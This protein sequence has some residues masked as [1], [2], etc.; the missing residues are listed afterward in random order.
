MEPL[1]EEAVRVLGCLVEKEATVPD[2]YPLTLNALRSAC[3]Q[4]SSRDPVV[5]YDDLTVQRSLDALKAAGLVRFVHPSH[6]ERATKFRHT[7]DEQLGLDHAALSVLSLLALRGPQTTGELRTRAERQHRF[8]SSAD[9][10]A[11]LAQLAGR[12]Q[13]L[14]VELPRRPGH[15]GTRWTHLLCGPVDAEAL[16]MAPTAGHTIAGAGGGLADR[17]EALE[18]E[19]GELRARLHSLED[20]LGIE[21]TTPVASVAEGDEPPDHYS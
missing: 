21:S 13:P 3:N 7:A 6:G 16:A 5:S 18:A 8:D 12:E 2:A 19:V 10:E 14:V 4:T 9:V 20:A 1:S 17:V 15:H 11:V